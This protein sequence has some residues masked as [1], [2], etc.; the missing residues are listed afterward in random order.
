MTMQLREY[1][2]RTIDQLYAL[3]C[4]YPHKLKDICIMGKPIIS[5]VGLKSHRWTVLSEAQK[6]SGASQTDNDQE[7]VCESIEDIIEAYEAKI[8]EKNNVLG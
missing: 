7:K 3:Q 5:M 2:Q 4:K 1:Q 8:R 6:P